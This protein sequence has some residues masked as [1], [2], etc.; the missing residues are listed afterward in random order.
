LITYFLL[1][2]TFFGVSLTTNDIEE[3]RVVPEND[4]K[5]KSGCTLFE[6]LIY[7]VKRAESKIAG[8]SDSNQ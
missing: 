2:T 6:K 3:E 7:I 5:Q 1:D 8:E 4:K